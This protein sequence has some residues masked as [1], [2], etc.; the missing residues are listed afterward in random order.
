[1]NFRC[2]QTRAMMKREVVTKRQ[3]IDGE[4]TKRSELELL[5]LL[6]GVGRVA[7]VAVRS[8]LEVLGLLEVEFAD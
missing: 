5:G 6:P 1:M 2:K 7:E 8:S 4:S 3:A